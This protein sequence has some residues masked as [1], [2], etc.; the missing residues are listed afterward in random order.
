MH[1]IE[2]PLQTIGGL[3]LFLFGM[4][5][6]SDGL[7]TAASNR[8]RN[9]LSYLTKN[10]AIALFIGAGVTAIIQSSSATSVLVVGFVNAGL[11]T[12]KQA[13]SVV[14]GA[15]IG[16]TF[17]A[18]IVS[19]VGKFSISAF[20]LP[21]IGIG[22]FMRTFS[23]RRRFLE[24]GEIM[25]G[26]GLVFFGL[27]IMKDAFGPMKNS[28][29]AINMFA[30][31]GKNPLLGV[32]VGM[33][34]TMLIQSSSAV[35]A[36]IQLLAFNGVISF[37]ASIILIFGSN[38]GTTITA[39]LAS[40]GT[41]YNTKCTARANSLFNLFG[42]IIF[43]PFAWTGLYGSLVEYIFPGEITKTN[44]MAHIAV[45]HSIFNILNAVVFSA[46]I[47][48]LQK[49]AKKLT[50]VRK[51]DDKL[52]P[53]FLEER[54]LD[55]PS[56]AM[57]Q[58]IKELIRMAE[59]AKATVEEA[60]KGFFNE[61]EKLL[62]KVKKGEQAI[63][64]FQ[65]A[66]TQYLVRISERHL[67]TRESSEYPI[68]L[69]S[70]NDLEKVGDYSV[71]IVNYA[72]TKIKNKLTINDSGKCHIEKMFEKLYELFDIV[73]KSLKT[74]DAENAVQAIKIEDEIDEMKAGCREEHIKRLKQSKGKPES[75][76]MIMDLATNIEKMGDHLISIAKAVIKD[77]QWGKKIEIA[78]SE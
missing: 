54:L 33:V 71:N 23:K 18:W 78:E 38:I 37:Q 65:E 39:E 29:I 22:F 69:H 47:D 60:Q 3:G 21:V 9:I 6:M 19:I 73:I 66:I 17:T 43:I 74:R 1:W 31:F 41:T 56:I 12:L 40:I 30:Y 77:L 44:I 76:I 13:V 51:G 14:I 63:D 2:I 15:N 52:M 59:L 57:D 28:Q 49:A 58:A 55:N 24:F 32:L 10:R 50:F 53:K 72:N 4:H 45:A 16:T 61:D 26:F 25:L 34:F 62:K 27:D 64:E 20:A 7:K 68:L 42:V 8:I 5:L 36:I 70:V 11:L 75:E 67:D 46:S 48:L 35:I